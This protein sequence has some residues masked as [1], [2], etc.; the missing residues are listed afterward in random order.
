M[1]ESRPFI[2]KRIFVAA[3]CAALS[4]CV[5]GLSPS[6]VAETAVA[7]GQDAVLPTLGDL[8]ALTQ[9]RHNKLWYA[10]RTQNWKLAN[11]ELNQLIKTVDRIVKLYPAASSV[12]Q[13]NLIHEQ[14]DPALSDLGKAIRDRSNSRFE[15]AFI[16]I[17]HACNECHQAAGVDF[18]VVQTPS[19]SPF[20]NQDFF[21]H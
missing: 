8:M 21:P 12:G 7:E 6:A 4:V 19:S 3:L 11:Y 15:A 2:S 10:A 20:S 17:T 13:A 5:A 16:Q 9:L 14:T 1:S 18:I